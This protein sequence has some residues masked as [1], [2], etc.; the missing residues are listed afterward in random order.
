LTRLQAA[1]SGYR[2]FVAIT[3]ERTLELMANVYRALT[4]GGSQSARFRS[5]VNAVA[6]TAPI[7][8]YNPMTS[9]PVIDTIEAL[10]DA[11]AEDRL[12][13]VATRITHLLGYRQDDTM[14]ITVATPGM[15][16]DRLA[17]EVEHR[18]LAKDPGGLL[19]W[20]AQAI[21]AETLDLEIVTQTVRLVLQRRE[22]APSNLTAAAHQ[23]GVA[24]ATAGQ[25]GEFHTGAAEVLEVLGNDTGLG[26]MVAFLYGDTAATNMGFAPLGLSGSTGYAHAVAAAHT[27]MH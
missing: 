16:T 17:T 9:A 5:Y 27:G 3:V 15:W 23:E 7:Q 24:G 14:H 26:T 21:N 25:Q 1:S 10:I 11:Q 19:W 22:G 20:C 8:G 18:L 13:S 4:F 6:A 12:E 2:F